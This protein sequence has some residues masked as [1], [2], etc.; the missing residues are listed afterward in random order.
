MSMVGPLPKPCVWGALVPPVC[1]LLETMSN[2]FIFPHRVIDM[3]SWGCYS[4][5]CSFK[6]LIA[7]RH[8][9][10]IFEISNITL[11]KAVK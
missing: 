10:D 1:P 4:Y 6:F 11:R 9:I 7:Q 8:T 5:R 3:A 2:I